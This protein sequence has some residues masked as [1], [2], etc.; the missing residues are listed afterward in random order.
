MIHTRNLTRR[1]SHTCHT[2]TH[3]P[4]SHTY[5]TLTHLPHP[6]TLHSILQTLLEVAG[7]FTWQLSSCTV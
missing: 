7:G 2:L 3:L 6:H 4:H 5:H 1:S